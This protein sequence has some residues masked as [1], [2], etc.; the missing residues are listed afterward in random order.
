M[1]GP[2]AAQV[3]EFEGRGKIVPPKSSKKCRVCGGTFPD[4]GCKK[5]NATRVAQNAAA[6][7]VSLDEKDREIQ[8]LKDTVQ[9]L[10]EQIKDQDDEV[11]L[12]NKIQFVEQLLAC[13]DYSF[14]WRTGTEA[15]VK[16]S[17]TWKMLLRRGTNQEEF[18][19]RFLLGSDRLV[20]HRRLHLQRYISEGI[21]I[22]DYTC[23]FVDVLEALG[24]NDALSRD[25]RPI[26]QTSK[27]LSE[28]FLKTKVRVV[29]THPVGAVT[30]EMTISLEYFVN[31]LHIGVWDRTMEPSM[32][33][34]RMVQ[35]A[36]G[37]HHIGTNRYDFSDSSQQN[38]IKVAL[39]WVLSQMQSNGNLDFQLA[40]RETHYSLAMATERQRSNS[41]H[42][43]A[44]NP[45]P[46]LAAL[47][48]PMLPLA[49]QSLRLLAPIGMGFAYHRLT[50]EMQNPWWK[51]LSKE[52]Q[53]SLQ[54]L[55]LSS[56]KSS[57]GSL[58]DGLKSI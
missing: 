58:M 20:D 49:K 43:G 23:T 57:V 36:R 53:L 24:T 42:W 4:C 51:A 56:L 47:C 11:A 12:Q 34:T 54:Q 5:K 3:K 17:N 44:Y 33:Q 16:L 22:T 52:S 37:F 29:A 2:T 18:I 48:L 40:P 26:A 38:T 35:A 30:Q 6:I 7:G 39:G 13:M 28:R 14:S 27:Q 46:S 31:L 10:Q 8:A 41:L 45:A 50:Q 21:G 9:A 15:P 32:I 55:I 25:Y 1:Q 19:D